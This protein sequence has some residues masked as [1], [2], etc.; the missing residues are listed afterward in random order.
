MIN[1]PTPSPPLSSLAPGT[2][3]KFARGSRRTPSLRD[4]LRPHRPST[5]TIATIGIAAVV[6]ALAP[7]GPLDERARSWALD[8]TAPAKPSRSAIVVE[9]TPAE[10]RR[11]ACDVALPDAV[12]RGRATGAL[13]PPALDA[14]CDVQSGSG[15]ARLPATALRQDAGGAILGFDMDAPELEGA[16]SLGLSSARW[17]ARRA[18][19]SVPVVELAAIGAGRVPPSVL[20]DRVVIASLAVRGT[21]DPFELRVADAVAGALDGA[22]RQETPWWTAPPL[23]IAALIGAFAAQKSR[24][25][26]RAVLILLGALVLAVAL[27]L[28]LALTGLGLWPLASVLAA[29]GVGFAGLLLAAIRNWQ[30]TVAGTS[31]LLRGNVSVRPPPPSEN[32]EQG[33]SPWDMVQALAADAFAADR[34]LV[35]AHDDAAHVLR[36]HDLPDEADLV[37]E[38]ERDPRRPPYRDEAGLVVVQIV[39]GFLRGDD[40]PALLVPMTAHGELQGYVVLVGTAA[41]EAH[42]EDPFR[43]QILGEELGLLLHRASTIDS[44]PP[45]LRRGEPNKLAQLMSRARALAEQTRFL[46]ELAS[47]LPVGAAWADETGRVRIINKRFASALASTGLS[48]P[49][50]MIRGML[51]NDALS[52]S[53][54]IGRLAGSEKMDLVRAMRGHGWT[55]T[56]SLGD[57]PVTHRLTV[58][59][60][61]RRGAGASA[62]AGYVLVL[63]PEGETW[64]T[65]HSSAPPSPLGEPLTSVM[66][67]LK[68][69]AP[70]EDRISSIAP[71]KRSA[72]SGAAS[73][74]RDAV[75]LEAARERSLGAGARAPQGKSSPPAAAKR[76]AKRSKTKL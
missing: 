13:L 3:G 63:A 15:V 14:L 5:I 75:A 29:T 62:I 72:A 44:A 11:G 67:S 2:S 37:A 20:A 32:E 27:H 39:R 22:V 24:G 51:P 69:P 46:S 1:P 57:P 66:R 19:G 10:L 59:A 65:D 26:M 74:V 21:G 56:V 68:E 61:R 53:G 76:R 28:V 30:K 38:P 70:S 45:S 58:R 8:V 4:R 48:F 54:L 40:R 36:F 7:L 42:L 17:V 64:F 55:T 60:E 9:I 16:R 41:V 23:P 33:A 31:A 34:V 49:L 12:R 52:L 35:A 50:E 25:G 6:A 47:A 18:R 73:T 71:T 43:A